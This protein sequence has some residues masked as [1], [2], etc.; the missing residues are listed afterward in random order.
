MGFREEFKGATPIDINVTS[1]VK[2][3]TQDVLEHADA[4]PYWLQEYTQLDKGQF[5]GSI[6]S[7][8]CQGIQ[9]FSE[10]MDRAVDQIACA[11]ADCYVIGLPTI[12]DGDSTWG[13]LPTKPHSLITLDKNTELIFR[14]SHCSEITAAV[15]SANRLEEYAELVEW[16]DLRKVLGNLKPVEILTPSLT[17]SLL[18]AMLSS[19]RY[20]TNMQYNAQDQHFWK[21]IEDNLLSNCI[22]ALLHAKN[23]P[24]RQ[25]DHRIHR[26]IVNRVR[27]TTIENSDLPLSISQICTNLRI[28]R[29]TLN[30]AFVRVLGITPVE[31]IRNLRLHRIRAELQA[32]PY[33]A[34]TITDVAC[35][36]GFWHR[37]LFTRYY[38]ELFGEC[39]TETLSR[40]PQGKI[41]LKQNRMKHSDISMRR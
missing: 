22:Q 34:T 21:Q 25:H 8:A 40:D 39:P 9:V 27:E 29:R 19:M 23:T 7:A 15:I 32:Q 20:I 13:L 31:Y 26:Y 36:W 38:K 6:T 16:V 10:H 14:T 37:S 5:N 2:C 11:P 41:S 24:S 17:G 4:L 28:S 18:N 12:V 33:Y 3:N 1:L 35:K 30:H